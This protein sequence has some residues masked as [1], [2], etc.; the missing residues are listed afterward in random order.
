MNLMLLNFIENLLN[1][2]IQMPNF[3]LV[4]VTI[5]V[6]ELMLTKKRHL[7]CIRRQ[8]KKERSAQNNLGVLYENGEGTKKD[9]KMAFYWYNKAAENGSKVSLYNLGR[10]Y[11]GGI[12]I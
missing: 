5:K 9:L 4:I 7:F 12:G 11:E 2:N 6:L 3:N 1:R 8:L 10:C